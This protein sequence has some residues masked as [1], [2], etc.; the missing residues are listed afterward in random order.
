M[1]KK[2]SNEQLLKIKAGI[3]ADLLKTANRLQTK[4][5]IT[6]TRKNNCGQL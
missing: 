4:A 1:C 6:A 2:Y 3:P 5:T